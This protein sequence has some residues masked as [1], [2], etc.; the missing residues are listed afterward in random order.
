MK[1]KLIKSIVFPVLFCFFGTLTG[2][3]TETVTSYND[4]YQTVEPGEYLPNVDY[5]KSLKILCVGNSFSDNA[6]AYMYPIAKAFGIEEVKIANLY[7]GGCSLE[8]HANNAF[9]NTAA[10]TY[11]EVNVDTGGAIQTASSTVRMIDGILDEDWDIITMQQVSGKSG[12]S[13]TY[14]EDLVGLNGYIKDNA[15]NPNV[16]FGWHMTWAYQQNSTHTDFRDYNRDQLNMYYAIRKATKDCIEGNDMFDF[17]VPAGTAVQ[18]ARTSY[19]G[20][21]LTQDGYH[22]N[23]KGEY[24]I[25]LTWI[26]KITGLTRENFDESK[27]PFAFQ[28]ELDVFFESAE[29]AIKDPYKITNSTILEAPAVP[30]IDLTKYNVIDWNPVIGYWNS[31]DG[32]NYNKLIT[33]AGNSTTYM[34]TE[35]PYTKEDIP[36]GSIIEL[37]EGWAYRPEAW[38]NFDER[39]TSRPDVCQESRVYVDETWWGNYNYRAFNVYKPGTANLTGQEESVKAAFKIYVPK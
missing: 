17:V 35:T 29:N 10:Y 7:I 22:L 25:G 34:S 14:N 4:S 36:L 13:S 23:D 26:M 37:Q 8:T 15:T 19:L 12:V 16:Q 18:N 33:S 5:T 39:Q 9:N 1:N 32:A 6:I 2:C 38:V 21:N 3:K 30:K 27:A 28:H 11:R 31:N 24:I 20:D